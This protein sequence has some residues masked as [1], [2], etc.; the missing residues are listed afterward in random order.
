MKLFLESKSKGYRATAEYDPD[1]KKFMV[2]KGST[3]S[4]D[5]AHSEK[6]RGAKSIEATRAQHVENLTVREDVEFK[7]ASTAANFITG[8]STNGMITWKDKDG[9]KLK[10]LLA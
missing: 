5:V 9:T 10:D 1:S 6:F 2:L 4:A 3:V 7:S 8:R